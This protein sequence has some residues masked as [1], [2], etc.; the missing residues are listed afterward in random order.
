MKIYNKKNFRLG[1]YFFMLAAG[2]LIMGFL[3]E[4]KPRGL[5]WQQ[6]QI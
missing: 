2:L 4:F 3:K 5:V 1:I 6:M